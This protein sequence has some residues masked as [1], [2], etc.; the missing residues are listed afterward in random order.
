M[1]NRNSLAADDTELIPPQASLAPIRGLLIGLL[2]IAVAIV[3]AILTKDH[4][5]AKG[6][7]NTFDLNGSLIYTL[8]SG[9]LVVIEDTRVLLESLPWL[10]SIVLLWVAF[11]SGQWGD[12]ALWSVAMILSVGQLTPEFNRLVQWFLQNIG[13]SKHIVFSSSFVVI[14]TISYTVMFFACSQ[15]A[16]N[17]RYRRLFMCLSVV[18][19]C[20]IYAIRVALDPTSLTTLLASAVL[21]AGYWWIGVWIANRVGFDVYAADEPLAA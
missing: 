10:I 13:A 11:A 3:F 8:P 9:V 7:F 12:R 21:S 17:F 6:D 20:A 15:G 2:F 14:A 19:L 5:G 18:A 1:D 4:Y 16:K